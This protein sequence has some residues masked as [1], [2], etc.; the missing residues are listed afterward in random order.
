MQKFKKNF[1]G[2][3]NRKSHV[4]FRLNLLFFVIFTLFV[5]LIAQLGHLQIINSNQLEEQ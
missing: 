3:A 5:I 2:N 1:S 4:P